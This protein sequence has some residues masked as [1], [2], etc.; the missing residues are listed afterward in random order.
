MNAKVVMITGCAGFIGS[1]LTEECLKRGWYV[2][3]VDKLSYCSHPNL[4]KE[5]QSVYGQ[6][7]TF[8]HKDINNLDRL[9]DFD[10]ILNLCAES[11]VDNAIENSD[12]F[13]R[14]NILG[15]H[16]LCEL[17]RTK[18]KRPLFFQMSTDECL[19]DILEGSHT[20]MDILNPSNP[21]SFSKA[22][23]DLMVSAF[24]RTYGIQYQIVRATNNW[25]K[26]QNPEKLIPRMC[27][28]LMLGKKMELHNMG[29]PYRMW[30]HVEDCVNGILTV[31]DKG[32][33][34][35]I[36][37]VSGGYEQQNI[38][39]VKKIINCWLKRDINTH[40]SDD[41]MKEYVDF[42]YSRPGQDVRY[43][44]DDSKLR[45]L[46]WQPIKK[47]DETLPSV[48]DYYRDKFIW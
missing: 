5:F 32:N 31:I 3:G 19:G 25:G 22:S 13:L 34:N 6:H 41:E 47:F 29:T 23:A 21:Y 40:I 35:E 8:I 17:I 27:K 14:S 2:Y 9:Y 16:H 24:N 44:L 20:E 18:R 1:H 11:H 28:S 46:G 39:T 48:I 30:L 12:E 7:F 36:Y 38:V 4:M 45:N 37:N 33:V 26:R 10:I 43:S 42:N 15:P